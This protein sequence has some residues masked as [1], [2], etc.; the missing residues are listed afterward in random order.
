MFIKAYNNNYY[1]E[2]QDL[3]VTQEIFKDIQGYEGKYQVSN[4][5]QVKSIAKNKDL[6]LKQSSKNKRGYSYP[7]VD[8]YDKYGKMKTFRVHRLVSETFIPNPY[9]LPCVNHKD[10]D[11]TNNNVTNLEWCTYSENTKHAYDTNLIS[12]HMEKA[13]EKR[14]KNCRKKVYCHQTNKV[15]NSITEASRELSLSSS[16]VGE[17]C[18]GSIKQTKGYTFEFIMEKRRI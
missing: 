12:P 4:K 2:F 18:K 10:G 17:V 7:T 1:K 13:I 5:G 16:K 3:G 6:I 9:N 11:K 14:A 15:Y 8:L